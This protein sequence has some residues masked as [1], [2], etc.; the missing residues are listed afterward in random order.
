MRIK[1]KNKRVAVGMSGG[2]DS[3]AVAAMLV[4]QGFDVIGLTAHMWKEGSRC[5]SLE[6]VERARS[7]CDFLDIRHYVVNAQELFTEKIVDPFVD[8][9]ASG[10]TPSPCIQCNAFIKFGFL[11]TRA[12]QL[13]CMA[14]AT[15]HYARVEQDANGF[16][17]LFCAKDPQKDQSYFLH[18]LN[19]YQL[20]RLMFPL[21]NLPKEKVRSYSKDRGLPIVSRGDSQDLCFIEEGKLAHFIEQRNSSV[22]ING[23]IVDQNGRVV[24]THKGLHHFTVGQ[25]GGLGVALGERMYVKRLDKKNNRV[26]IAP[27]PGVSSEKCIIRDV[28]WINEQKEKIIRCKVRPRYGSQGSWANVS[29]MSDGYAEINF[30]DP[31]FALAPGQAAVFY[32]ENEVLGGG[33]IDSVASNEELVKIN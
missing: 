4:D 18:R 13:D 26:E 28:H 32:K 10:E 5:C 1:K 19:Q 2:T 17:R 7:V 33:W 14:V 12:E 6:D 25:R 11:L 30:E 31:Q 16:F 20:E 15:G 21:A 9:Y 3:S 23:E 8:G 27:R 24:G 22:A 29:F